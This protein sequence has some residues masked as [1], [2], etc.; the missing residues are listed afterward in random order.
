MGRENEL[1]FWKRSAIH[2]KCK[3]MLSFWLIL[4][5]YGCTKDIDSSVMSLAVK[6]IT[7]LTMSMQSKGI[8]LAKKG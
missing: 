3:I 2:A 8:I 1:E 7:F 6:L 5:D 4:V